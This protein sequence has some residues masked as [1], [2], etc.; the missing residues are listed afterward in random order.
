MSGCR[1]SFLVLNHETDR[2][3]RQVASSSRED[4]AF[5]AS[6][7]HFCW[8]GTCAVNQPRQLRPAKTH[9]AYN[10]RQRK[11]TASRTM[12]I[13]LAMSRSIRV[14]AL[15]T[16]LMLLLSM[17]FNQALCASFQS[18][19]STIHLNAG[20]VAGY[21]IFN[22]QSHLM[23]DRGDIFSKFTVVGNIGEYAAFDAS[24][25][26]LTTTS[27]PIQPPTSSNS[28][29]VRINAETLQNN[30][31]SIATTTVTIMVDTNFTL[32]FVLADSEES[33]S[34]DLSVPQT[35]E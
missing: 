6:C 8:L 7:A 4:H 33:L 18:T 12:Y 22:A 27:T 11:L 29:F 19:Q 20:T 30:T 26:L 1:D 25:G 34:V 21:E 16:C 17:S 2:D 5:Q 13:M 31:R 23:L 14:L 28:Y 35:Q 9:P 32:G 15:P 3:N 24:S 10:H